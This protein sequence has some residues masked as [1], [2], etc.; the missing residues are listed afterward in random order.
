MPLALDE[1]GELLRRFR[2][3]HVPM[4]LVLDAQGRVL[5]RAEGFDPRLKEALSAPVLG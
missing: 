1:S 4:V 3:M 5:R 2:V